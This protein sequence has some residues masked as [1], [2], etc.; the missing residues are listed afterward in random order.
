MPAPSL[1]Q[2]IFAY[3]PVRDANSAHH[4][5]AK[6]HAYDDG[7]AIANWG[8]DPCADTWTPITIDPIETAENGRQLLPSKMPYLDLGTL[9][10]DGDEA[11]TTATPILQPYGEFLPA[12]TES[13]RTDLAVFHP[14][15]L[16]SWGDPD[17]EKLNEFSEGQMLYLSPHHPREIRT[18]GT[19]RHPMDPHGAIYLSDEL[20][21]ELGYAGLL[22]GTT[23][24]ICPPFVDESE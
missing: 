5:W 20:V 21:T 22:D 19:F 17:Y 13:G 8:F 1:V 16:I 15:G 9:L 6:L 11:I 3:R 2:S 10:F 4:R 18:L 12:R 23:F 7:Q 14:F 24:R